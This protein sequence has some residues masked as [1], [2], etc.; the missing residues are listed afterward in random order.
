MWMDLYPKTDSHWNQLGSFIAA[1]LV[2]ARIGKVIPPVV[3]GWNETRRPGDLGSKLDPVEASPRLVARLAAKSYQIYDNLL[4]NNGRVRVFSKRIQATE[5]GNRT[6]KLLM[7]G[8]SFSY[9]MIAFFQ[10]SVR[11]RGPRSFGLS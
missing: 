9:D 4:P 2:C 10:R 5:P 1:E 6:C 3:I 11:Y 7:F 8:D